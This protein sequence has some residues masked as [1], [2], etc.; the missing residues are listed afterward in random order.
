MSTNN[1]FEYIYKRIDSED[2]IYEHINERYGLM[3]ENAEDIKQDLGIINDKQDKLTIEIDYQESVKDI[4]Q[5]NK[6]RKKKSKPSVVNK[7]FNIELEQLPTSLK[8][9]TN[10]NSTTGFVVWQ[11]TFFF[12]N[13]LLK[14]KGKSFLNWDADKN[15]DIIELGTGINC[16]NSIVLANFTRNFYISTDQKGIL[17]KLK[18]NCLNNL[19]EIKK[20]NNT[21]KL[22]IASLEINNSSKQFRSSSL[23]INIQ[24]DN[25][26]EGD[27]FRYEVLH[28]DWCDDATYQNFISETDFIKN[29]DKDLLSILAVDVIYNEF[30]IAP[31]IK[32][33]ERLLKLRK[34]SQAI[35]VLQ[36]RDESIIID[37]LSECLPY[38][39]I[40][41]IEDLDSAN[42][43]FSCS[44]H[45]IYKLTLL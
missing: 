44:R 25:E 14:H 22:N 24:T 32:T 35:V 42:G 41:V 15:V 19:K 4:A 37:F 6:N 31:F 11:S 28:L 12:L 38:F 29:N 30:L 18:M 13:W 3:S 34:D 1:E 21:N 10:G 43:V 17:N 8:S 9:N 23:N 45:V 20:Y 40:D 27:D 2:L 39:N 26:T 16:S 36:L 5:P 33:V 7:N